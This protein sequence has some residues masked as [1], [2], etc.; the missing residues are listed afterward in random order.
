MEHHPDEKIFRDCATLLRKWYNRNGHSKLSPEVAKTRDALMDL[1]HALSARKPAESVRK[2]AEGAFVAMHPR[3]RYSRPNA[4]A[5]FAE[6]CGFLDEIQNAEMTEQLRAKIPE[7]Q[8]CITLIA[9]TIKE[10][11]HA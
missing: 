9:D 8:T 11:R 10:M 2:V 4:I 3:S 5:A 6:I 1:I 7:P